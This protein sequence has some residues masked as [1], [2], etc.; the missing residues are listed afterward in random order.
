[1][2]R[3]RVDLRDV[4]SDLSARLR[5]RVGLERAFMVWHHSMV[6]YLQVEAFYDTR[7]GDWSRER[8]QAGLEIQLTR[9]WRL[10]PY[11]RWQETR[12]PS[13]SHENG[14]GLVLKYFH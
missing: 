12:H 4:G 8:Y 5:P 3:A 1:V 10:E 11:F 9:Q 2:N 13:R 7:F 6:P 14:V